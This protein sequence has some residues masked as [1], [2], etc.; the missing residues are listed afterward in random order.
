MDFS[1]TFDSVDR[2]KIFEILKLYGIPDKM[3]AAIRVLYTNTSSTIL[4]SD[5]ETAFSSIQEGILQGDTL[6]PF[7]FIIVVDYVLGM[8]VD[9]INDKGYQLNPK[10]SSRY[11]AKYLTD[12]D[13]AEDI[14][15]ICQSLENAQALLQSLEQ[16]SNCVGLYL[17]ESKTEYINKCTTNNDHTIKTLNN[18]S[19]SPVCRSLS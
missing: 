5:G 2:T 16:A 9:T 12:T 17:N 10:R 14:A 7:L 19:K 18:A 13:F 8:S 11:P 6:A 3:I 15:L 4:T 1:K